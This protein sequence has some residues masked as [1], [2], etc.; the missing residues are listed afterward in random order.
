[1]FLGDSSLNLD[2]KGR[3]AIPAKYR[4]ALADC[5]ASRVV[6]TASPWDECLWL[7]PRNT[8]DD[9]ARSV[10]RLPDFSETNRNVK[11]MVLGLAADLDMDGQGR[12]LLPQSLRRHASMDKAVML[13]GQYNKCEIWSAERWTEKNEK[14][15]AAANRPDSELSEELRNLSF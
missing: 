8:W 10:A 5:C 15:R 7:Y 11:R 12:V 14:M 2:A 13:I 6:V 3:L 1:M 4:G 9:L